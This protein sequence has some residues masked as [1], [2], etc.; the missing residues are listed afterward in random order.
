MSDRV[1][2]NSHFMAQWLYRLFPRLADKVTVV[3]LGVNLERFPAIGDPDVLRQRIEH[4]KTMGLEEK[5]VLL[6]V[7]RVIQQ[8]GLH[9]LLHALPMIREKHPD[10]VLVIVGSSRYGRHVETTYAKRFRHR[11]AH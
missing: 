7:G 11:S 10:T 3:P 9:F 6:Y 4:R 1:M 8:K 5:K 2:T